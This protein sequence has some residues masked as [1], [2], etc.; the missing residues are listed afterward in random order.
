MTLQGRCQAVGVRELHDRL[1]HYLREVSAGRE[2]VV[3][4][5]GKPIAKLSPV[6]QPD[7]LDELQRAGLI[8]EPT[9]S[10]RRM[11]GRQRPAPKQPVADTVS[12]HRD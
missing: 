5:R 3:T 8:A 10:R 6:G 9:A 1:S 7:A 12:Q 2:V 4:M 11:S